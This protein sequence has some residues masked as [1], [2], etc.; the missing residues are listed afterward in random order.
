MVGKLR[1]LRG[2]VL[3]S[4]PFVDLGAV[5]ASTALTGLRAAAF[6]PDYA[7]NGTLFVWF[8]APSGLPEPNLILARLQRSATNPDQA[9]PTSLVEL[10]VEPQ[11]A[12]GHGGGALH[13]GPDGM[14]YV[15]IGDGGLAND[16]Q[17]NGQNRATLQGSLLRLDVDGG[18]PYAIPFDNPYAGHPNW[19]GEIWHY[20]FRHPWKWSFDRDT[21]DLWIADVGQHVAEEVNHVPAGHAGLN[22]GWKV[23]EGLSCFQT[24]GCTVPTRPCLDPGLTDPIHAYGHSLGCSVTG[25][26]VYRGQAIPDFVGAYVFA[27]FCSGRFWCLREEAGV[28]VGYQELT[29]QLDP[30]GALAISAPSA[31]GEDSAGELYVIDHADAEIYKLT[32]D[33]GVIRFCYPAPNATGVGARALWTGNVSISAADL[34]LGVDGVPPVSF[35]TYFYGTDIQAT[36]LGNGLLCIAPGSGALYRLGVMNANATGEMSIALDFANPPIGSGP[37][38]AAVGVTLNFQCWYRDNGGPL[39]QSSNFTDALSVLFCP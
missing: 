19:R 30:P 21:G 22:F 32:R 12:R 10:L 28:M 20:G 15:L 35:G 9:D 26:F 38:L 18:F 17:C 27:D 24:L 4:A 39:G 33:C 7:A 6:H 23:M 11:L 14:L 25:G 37:G 34:V 36:P 3:E 1:I 16:P 8:D 29:A 13:F 2:G 31:F 5:V